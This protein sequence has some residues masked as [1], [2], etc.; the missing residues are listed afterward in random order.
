LPLTRRVLGGVP[1]STLDDVVRVCDPSMPLTPEVDDA[2]RENLDAIRGGDRLSR[3]IRNI[4]RAASLP[5]L[6]FLTGHVGTGKT[7]ELLR[8][9]YSAEH[10]PIEPR[11]TVILLDA[12]ALVEIGDVDLEDI[13]VALWMAVLEQSTRAAA[14]VLTSLWESDIR[15][16][17]LS[18][19]T[20]APETLAAA[21]N[22]LP[23]T[24]HEGLTKLIDALKLQPPEQRKALRMVLGNIADALISGL[25][26]ALELIRVDAAGPVVVLLDNLEKLGE[27]RRETVD[28]L[29]LERL[30]ALKRLDA[31]L[32][33]TA[34]SYLAYAAS[35]ASLAG[36]YG[37]EVVV[38]PMV[39][40]R[41]RRSAGGGDDEAGVGAMVSL[42]ERSVHFESLFEGGA[43]AAREIAVASGGC[44]R[45]A[46]Q[47]VRSAVNMHDDPPVLRASV[48]RA[49][50][51]LQAQLDRA[52]PE[53]W[54]AAL[55]KVA[56]TNRFPGDCDEQV[57]RETLRHLFVLE[58]QNGEPEPFYCVH[59]LVE[60]S[61]K[62]REALP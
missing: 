23:K 39:K 30:G 55:Q 3:V 8:M 51:E 43:S 48:E 37:G 24:A 49:I 26:R 10:G 19:L 13:L 60:R 35:G 57:K 53:R 42:L 44:I 46:L 5:T 61:R 56:D 58:Y 9:K 21:L 22:Q 59:P 36:L 33:I 20:R 34:P 28:H 18:Q 11:P 4:R 25:N 54:I 2:L 50:A 62:F 15:T 29:F 31:H 40:V 32:V 12:T 1:A 41:H 47:M 7:T 27:R 14:K 17:I 6:Q 16:L 45:H 38:L 52:L